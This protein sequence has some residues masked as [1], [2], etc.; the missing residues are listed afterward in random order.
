M[1]KNEI[2]AYA[3]DKAKELGYKPGD[4]I[5]PIIEKLGG[6]IVY[7]SYTKWLEN[8]SPIIEIRGENDFTVYV[9]IFT[10][11]LRDNWTMAAALGYYFL[12]I[13]MN[14]YPI[15][16]LKHGIKKNIG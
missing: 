12:H 1:T 14:D 5:K 8:D 4:K 16:I 7:Q 15:T 11:P 10:G 9:T 6:V 2:Y 3:E 13:K